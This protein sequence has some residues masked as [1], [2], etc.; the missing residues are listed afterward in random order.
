MKTVMEPCGGEETP[1]HDVDPTNESFPWNS[2]A[3]LL[4]LVDKDEVSPSISRDDI[5][6]C[7]FTLAVDINCLV[8]WKELAMESTGHPNS[9]VRSSP[10]LHCSS[11][12]DQQKI[13][14]SSPIIHRTQQ[15]SIVFFCAFWIRHKDGFSGIGEFLVPNCILGATLY[16]LFLNAPIHVS[17]FPSVETGKAVDVPV[18]LSHKMRRNRPQLECTPHVGFGIPYVFLLWFHE[19]RCTLTQIQFPTPHRGFANLALA[20]FFRQ[21]VLHQQKSILGQELITIRVGQNIQYNLCL[22]LVIVLVITVV[23]YNF[24][25]IY[26]MIGNEWVGFKRRHRIGGN[27]GIIQGKDMDFCFAIGIKLAALDEAVGPLKEL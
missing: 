26:M 6:N 14:F 3:C 11:V 23:F 19:L 8:S 12:Q 2:S 13:L 22:P 15:N 10:F 1:V 5:Q 24:I 16:I 25:G 4:L 17:C 21:H 7:L 9:C 20:P 18:G 27:L